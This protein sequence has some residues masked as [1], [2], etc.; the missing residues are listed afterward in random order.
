MP[1]RLLNKPT[2]GDI[3]PKVSDWFALTASVLFA[4]TAFAAFRL[5]L[6]AEFVDLSANYSQAAAET[7]S[8]PA[9]QPERSLPALSEDWL[10]VIAER[11]VSQLGDSGAPDAENG[12]RTAAEETQTET[13]LFDETKPTLSEPVA[14]LTICLLPASPA[15]RRSSPDSTFYAEFNGDSL[16]PRAPP[17]L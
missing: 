3:A 12:S 6:L 17:V 7:D 10:A 13:A 8:R 4:M 9:P 2:A 11:S 14:N 1:D 5:P 15:S 16:A